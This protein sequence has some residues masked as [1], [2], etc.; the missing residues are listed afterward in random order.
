MPISSAAV[1]KSNIARER[2][3]TEAVV[4]TRRR[5]GRA[6]SRSILRDGMA[7]S[8]DVPTH[9]SLSLSLVGKGVLAYSCPCLCVHVSA[10]ACVSECVYSSVYAHIGVVARLAAG[11][12]ISPVRSHITENHGSFPDT[13]DTVRWW[14]SAR[15]DGTGCRRGVGRWVAV[16][17]N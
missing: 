3:K 13:V 4:P 17:A 10:R 16:S 2:R 8:L 12:A 7:S 1:Q 15:G 5:G 9:L 6:K 14:V 11:A